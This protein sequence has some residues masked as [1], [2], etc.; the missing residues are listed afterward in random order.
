MPIVTIVLVLLVVGFVLYL[1]QTVPIPIHPWFKM[2]IMGVLGFFAL[3]FVL[4][5]L[6]VHTGIPLRLN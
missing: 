1:I 2:V 3:V 4:N 5:M 6:G